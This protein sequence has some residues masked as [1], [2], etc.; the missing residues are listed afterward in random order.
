MN[1]D[2]ILDLQNELLITKAQINENEENEND[3]MNEN[4]KY[5]INIKSSIVKNMEKF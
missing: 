3:S 4:A 1:N 5:L 2:I